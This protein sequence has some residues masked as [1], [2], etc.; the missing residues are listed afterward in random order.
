[1][2]EVFEE[3]VMN[4]IYVLGVLAAVCF[5]SWGYQA[6]ISYQTTT[7]MSAAGEYSKA[8]AEFGAL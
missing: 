1:M 3:I 6:P 4:R 2:V 5:A 8:V 7:L